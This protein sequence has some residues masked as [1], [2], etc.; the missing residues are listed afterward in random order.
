MTSYGLRSFSGLR[1]RMSDTEYCW[2]YYTFLQQFI[3]SWQTPTTS[4]DPV[5][6]Q[7]PFWTCYL[8]RNL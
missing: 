7:K 6:Y 3:C 2:N 1:Q 5:S 8:L 4:R